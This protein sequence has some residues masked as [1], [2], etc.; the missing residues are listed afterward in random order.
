MKH[1]SVLFL[2]LCVILGCLWALRL[3]YPHLF[4]SLFLAPVVWGAYT[5]GS[6]KQMADFESAAEA[7]MS[8]HAV[9]WGWDSD[10]PQT[11]AG[12]Q[13]KTLLI[14]W[15]PHFGYDRILDGSKD[16]YITEFAKA[17]KAYGYPVIL[18]PFDEF[19]L[20][21]SAWGSGVG[22]NTPETFKATWKKIHEVFVAQAA[23]NVQFALVYNNHSI[24]SGTYADFYPGDAFVDYVGVD[25]FNFGGQTFSDIFDEALKEATTFGKP[26]WI[27]STGSV[28]P[29]AS[30]IL[31]LGRS[32][33]PWIWF[34]QAPYNIDQNSLSAFKSIL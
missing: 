10:F 22:S 9:F 20:N 21:E 19:N 30:F 12:S 11:T 27:F 25:G 28:A 14:F 18:A 1:L 5:G 34:N 13:G 32:G 26:V 3:G 16:H 6:D 17:A 29:K 33:Y 15:E 7:K 8:I 24:P 31:D 4:R 23:T 2:S